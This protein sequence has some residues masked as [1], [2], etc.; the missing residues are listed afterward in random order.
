M[1]ISKTIDIEE[2]IRLALADYMT[3]YCRPLPEDYALPCIL[4]SA[5]GGDSK[6]TIDAP[7][8]S[9]DAR[10]ETDAEAYDYLTDA[11]GVLE[12]QAEKQTGALRH[13]MINSLARWGVDPV[14]PDLKLCT[15]TVLVTVH[16]GTKE[17]TTS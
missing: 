12:A 6:D 4:V 16:R 10:A 15:A 17:I 11:L 8:V 3:A 9:I 5:T 2:E 1:E 14:R 13:I 7:T